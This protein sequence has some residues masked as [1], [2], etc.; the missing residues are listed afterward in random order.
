M[1]AP[2]ICLNLLTTYILGLSLPAMAQYDYPTDPVITEKG[3]GERVQIYSGTVTKLDAK[4][5]VVTL[6]S[7]DGQIDILAG[8]EVKNF[9]QIKLGDRL[10]I[11]YKLATVMELEKI[12]NNP[13]DHKVNIAKQNTVKTSASVLA[14]DRKSQILTLKEP[15]GNVLN[16]KIENPT[17]L[18]G[19]SVNDLVNVTYAPPLALK[20]NFIKK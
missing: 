8:P 1:T 19:L 10:N 14:I 2:R 15:Q 11:A 17:L 4:N 5:R 18:K 20:M 12:K 7:K 16:L 9:A 6:K 13:T 3:V